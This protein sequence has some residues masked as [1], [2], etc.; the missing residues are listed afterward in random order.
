MDCVFCDIVAG[1]EK[2]SKIYEDEHTLAFMDIGQVT[3][4]HVLVIPK[5]HIETIDEMSEQDALHLARTVYIITKAVKQAL[6][7]EGINIIQSNGKAAGQHIKHIH[8]HILP[9][10]TGDGIE[11]HFPYHRPDRRTLGEVAEEIKKYVV[12]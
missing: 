7:A 8:F 9:R 1:K 2:A 3:K 12:V 11:I 6:N 10:F 4:G 5:R